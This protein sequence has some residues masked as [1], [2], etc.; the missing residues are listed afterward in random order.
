MTRRIPVGAVQEIRSINRRSIEGHRIVNRDRHSR[1]F[2]L[3]GDAYFADNSIFLGSGELFQA[4]S[5]S[6]SFRASLPGP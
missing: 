4:Y 5:M 2:V 6:I 1:R 3:Y